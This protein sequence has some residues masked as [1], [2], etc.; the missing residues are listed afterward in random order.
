MPRSSLVR[1]TQ[2]LLA[3][4]YVAFF[5]WYTSWGGP[6]EPAEIGHY[7]ERM[8]E[9]GRS[10]EE[11][12][13]L[14]AFLEAD[15]GDDF[16][17]VNLIEMREPP[18]RVPGVGPDET[19]QQVLDRYMAFMWPELLRR[20]CHPVLMGQAAAPALDVWGI[21]DAEQWS[22][23]GV[24]RYRSRRDL[25]EIATNPGFAGPHEFKIAAMR[26]T[27]AFP[28]DPWL[29]LGDPRLLLGLV[30]A[31]IALALPRGR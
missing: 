29:Q 30:F 13:Q 22:V 21:E 25:M 8:R 10:P 19:A 2:V 23:A 12:A 18:T 20:A 6:L 4:L 5:A 1:A 16:V 24:M 15:T 31:V 9:R 28:A 3:L 14:L 11:I 27:L 7:A 26:K 17:M